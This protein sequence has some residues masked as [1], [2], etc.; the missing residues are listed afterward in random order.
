MIT[1]LEQFVAQQQLLVTKEAHVQKENKLAQNLILNRCFYNCRK[2]GKPAN[3]D[4]HR[5][6]PLY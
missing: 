1:F 3:K 4:R 2:S 5:A 6:I